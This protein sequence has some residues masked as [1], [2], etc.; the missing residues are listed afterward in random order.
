[1]SFDS[2][3][4]Y[5]RSMEYILAGSQLH[6]CRTAFLGDVTQAKTALLLGEGPG[7][8]LVELLRVNPSVKVT[9]VD[10]SDRMLA[11]ARERIR[12]Q[13]LSERNIRFVRADWIE[14]PG[15]RG[16]F[17]LVAT[18]FFLDCF[19]AD[20]LAEV[21]AKVRAASSSGAV[22]VLSDFCVPAGGWQRFRARL[23]L[24]LAY[25]FFRWA[26]DLPASKLEPPGPFLE[27]QGFQLLERRL[28]HYGLLYAELWRAL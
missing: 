26:T 18:H 28:F 2:L 23:V 5:Y 25:L 27:A 16:P 12:A 24:K 22:W 9:C 20:Q 10:S 7:R 19:R 3:A 11:A 15:E 13:R 14:R 17:D 8:Y 21:A 6:R 4:P 1:M